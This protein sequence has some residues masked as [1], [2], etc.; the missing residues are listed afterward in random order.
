MNR[1][2]QLVVFVLVAAVIFLSFALR[3]AVKNMNQT[4]KVYGCLAGHVYEFKDGVV[5]PQI[6]DDG[7]VKTCKVEA[8]VDEKKQLNERVEADTPK[9]HS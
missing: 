4:A 9:E 5:Y 7:K 2:L 8:P 1:V 3:D 6:D